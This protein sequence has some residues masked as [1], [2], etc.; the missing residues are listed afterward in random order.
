MK[1]LYIKRE[2]DAYLWSV[3]FIELNQSIDRI[4]VEKNFSI[5]T[6]SRHG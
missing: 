3:S 4:V 6:L 1:N 5:E 2:E